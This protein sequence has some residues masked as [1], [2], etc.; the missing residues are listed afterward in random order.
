MLRWFRWGRKARRRRIP[1]YAAPGSSCHC[2][3]I[4]PYGDPVVPDIHAQ[5]C[6]ARRA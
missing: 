6:P 2:W 4:G 1:G 3:T 5:W